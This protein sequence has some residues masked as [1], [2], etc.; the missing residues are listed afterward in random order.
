M[1]PELAR[2]PPNDIFEA[3]S[4]WL[5]V[6]VATFGPERIMFGSDWP[7]CTVGLDTDASGEGEGVAGKEGEAGAWN[8]WRLVV[9]RMCDMYGFDEDQTRMIFAGTARKA[10]GIE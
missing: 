9:E 10:Y 3:I 6:V 4:P 2:S 1:T 5:A 8:K 7:V